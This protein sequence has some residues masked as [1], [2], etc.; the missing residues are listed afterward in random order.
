MDSK[1]PWLVLKVTQRFWDE[2]HEML[3][4]GLKMGKNREGDGLLF[5]E[6]RNKF[7]TLR[8]TVWKYIDLSGVSK[9]FCLIF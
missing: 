9:G 6:V 2:G 3:F 1:K 4:F 5:N 7:T 8:R